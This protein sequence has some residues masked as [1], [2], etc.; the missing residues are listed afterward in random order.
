MSFEPTPI[1]DD[2]RTRRSNPKIPPTLKLTP[3]YW[4]RRKKKAAALTD[5]VWK[6]ICQQWNASR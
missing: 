5:R 4:K 1:Y 2:I 6:E 3:A